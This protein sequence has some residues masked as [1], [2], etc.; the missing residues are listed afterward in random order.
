LF[1]P[2]AQTSALETVL[3]AAD[4]KPLRSSSGMLV[5]ADLTFEEAEGGFDGGRRLTKK[6]IL[7]GTTAQRCCPT[8]AEIVS[9]KVFVAGRENGA[10]P[11]STATNA[12]SYTT[13]PCDTIIDGKNTRLI[14]LIR[15]RFVLVLT[16]VGSQKSERKHC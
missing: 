10:R 3:V 6:L 2:K 8:V 9:L 12:V 1:S 13:C 5:I 14:V 15:C 4:G 16:A 11:E 7:Y